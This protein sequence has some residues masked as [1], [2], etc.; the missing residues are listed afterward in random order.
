MYKTRNN[1]LQ[2]EHL[3]K[4]SHSSP[5]FGLLFLLLLSVHA[6][7]ESVY[8]VPQLQDKTHSE[9]FHCKSTEKMV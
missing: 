3:D 9:H 4:Q 8:H 2:Q 1:F 5:T 7:G 6:H